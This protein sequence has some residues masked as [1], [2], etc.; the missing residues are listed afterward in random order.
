MYTKQSLRKI[1]KKR[2]A[3]YHQPVFAEMFLNGREFQVTLIEK[4][5]GLCVLPPA[6]IIYTNGT[7]VPLLTYES[8]WDE[9][10]TD[11]SNSKV[12]LGKLSKELEQKI[13]AMSTS[14]FTSM[15]FR[16]YA[17]FDIRCDI[18]EQPYFLELNSN[19]G[20]GDDP[21]YGMT[22]SYK[23]AG[24]TF[25]DFV[26]EIVYSTLRRSVME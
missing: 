5:E 13:I 16:D 3:T 21:E 2:I 23:A 25:A 19:P 20:L 14:A 6:E 12:T 1:V 7:N 15:G 4:D 17:R 24:M 11:Y 8:R 10:H 18:N 26:V 9:H 22:I